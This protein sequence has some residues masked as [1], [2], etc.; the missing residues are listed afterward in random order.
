MVNA[1]ELCLEGLNLERSYWNLKIS[2]DSVFRI[3]SAFC[4]ALHIAVGFFFWK[5]HR[6]SWFGELLWV[7]LYSY[8]I[9]YWAK[10]N[11]HFWS[12]V[13]CLLVLCAGLHGGYWESKDEVSKDLNTKSALS[14]WGWA[15][16]VL[17]IHKRTTQR[18][19]NFRRR[20]V[21]CLKYLLVQRKACVK[22]FREVTPTEADGSVVQQR[23]AYS[24]VL[25]SPE[26]GSSE[27]AKTAVAYCGICEPA[28]WSLLRGT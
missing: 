15:K 1:R 28:V 10:L 13:L 7:S 8:K 9:Y 17:K 14:Y 27:A 20:G 4:F 6:K 2:R 3:A 5:Y 22:C 11:E 21:Q 18:K 24:M 26:T 19:K 12:R 23:R 16:L 25:R